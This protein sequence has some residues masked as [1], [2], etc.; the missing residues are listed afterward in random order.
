MDNIAIIITKLNGG[1]AERCASNLSIELNEFYNVFLIV[2]DG[3]DITYPY[4]GKLIDLKIPSSNNLFDRTVNVLKRVRKIQKIKKENNICCSISLLDGPNLV[5]VLSRYKDKA[6][7]SVRNRLSSENVGKLRKKLI[8]YSSK[9]ADLTISLSEMVKEDLIDE[10]G[11]DGSC[12]KTIYN[13]CDA[14][15]LTSL[16]EKV[17]KPDFMSDDKVYF[18]T[19][20]RLNRQ[21]GQWHLLRVFKEVLNKVPNVTL[22]ILGAGELEED[23][24]KLAQ[25]LRIDDHVI[26]T[27]YIQNPHVVFKYCEMFIFPSLFEGLGNVLLEALAFD[28]PIISSDCI[29]GPREILA[30]NTDYKTIIHEVEFAEYGV[31]VPVMDREHFNAYEDLT[32][33]EQALYKAIIVLH[34]NEK[35]RQDYSMKAK[36]RLLDFGKET[37]IAQWRECIDE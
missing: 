20:G 6:I 29:A 17:P 22:I 32:A 12:I 34:N 8:V 2:F 33:E 4:E 11:I 5:N 16:C 31:L 23:L 28:M 18:V 10:F 27:G 1:G 26:F 35:L 36:E 3:S 24:K 9:Q 25:N 14:E 15:L 37:I 19:M 13:H 30:P 21:K 7:V